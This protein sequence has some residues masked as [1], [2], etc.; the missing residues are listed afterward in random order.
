MGVS[1]ALTQYGKVVPHLSRPP[2]PLATPPTED[3]HSTQLEPHP[4]WNV[5]TPHE[6]IMKAI[7]ISPKLLD[8]QKKKNENLKNKKKDEEEEA[9]AAH[10]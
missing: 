4:M 2:L 1:S 7:K 6:I 10:N 5:L 8:N 9:A 3:T